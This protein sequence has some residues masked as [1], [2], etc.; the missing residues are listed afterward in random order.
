MLLDIALK[1]PQ[2]GIIDEKFYHK[3]KTSK[4]LNEVNLYK[5]ES[6]APHKETETKQIQKTSTKA[7]KK[8]PSLDKKASQVRTN[9]NERNHVTPT[10]TT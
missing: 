9:L 3:V 1:I 7:H 2:G 10:R 8:A 5:K 4:L 6:A